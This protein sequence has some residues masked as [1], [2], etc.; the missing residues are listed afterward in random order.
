MN[1][2]LPGIL[3]H[4]I[5]LN[6]ASIA[7]FF[8]AAS[9]NRRDPMIMSLLIARTCSPN[10][11]R[12]LRLTRSLRTKHCRLVRG[13]YT[14]TSHLYFGRAHTNG[15]VPGGTVVHMGDVF[16]NFDLPHFPA[17]HSD[18]DGTGGPEGEVAAIEYVLAHAPD[19][20]KI[21]PGHGA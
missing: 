20:A 1:A 18:N 13:K 21:I 4:P 10:T 17:L 3:L 11:C 6:T 7:L 14:S 9:R 16:T 8:S 19:D 12:P 2:V 15:D 5:L